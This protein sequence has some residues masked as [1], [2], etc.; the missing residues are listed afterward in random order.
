M[1]GTAL[2][3]GGALGTLGLNNRASMKGLTTDYREG[4]LVSAV[5]QE[6]QFTIQKGFDFQLNSHDRQQVK[7]SFGP[8]DPQ[9]LNRYSYVLNNP[10]RYEDPTGHITFG[11]GPSAYQGFVDALTDALSII[12]AAVGGAAGIAAGLG[13]GMAALPF[14]PIPGLVV[15]ALGAV[16]GVALGWVTAQNLSDILTA[17]KQA[18]AY[19]GPNGYIWIDYQPDTGTITVTAWDGTDNILWAESLVS[20]PAAGY[21][22]ALGLLYGYENASDKSLNPI[23]AKD[24]VKGFFQH[25]VIPGMPR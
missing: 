4:S 13:L 6:N 20:N 16:G 17:V 10:I 8:M 19:A 7:I 3:V 14:G 22:M 9:A 5:N 24:L 11:I 12:P 2:G 23:A 25:P 1:P 21:I 15:A 18:E